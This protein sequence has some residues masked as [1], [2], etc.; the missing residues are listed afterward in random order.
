[1]QQLHPDPLWD[2]GI[3]SYLMGEYEKRQV[4]LSSQD[5]QN[6]AVERA[7]RIGDMLETLFLMAIYGEW[8]YVDAEG[9]EQ[10]LDEEGLNNLYAKGR[11]TAADLEAF[12]GLWQPSK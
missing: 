1:M 12:N 5:L 6:F 10:P 8:Q 9:K 7:Q 2:E 11:I 3:A 4:P